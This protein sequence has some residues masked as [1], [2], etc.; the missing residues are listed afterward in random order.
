MRKENDNELLVRVKY[1]A[2]AIV[3]S[4]QL[5]GSRLDA[6]A[7]ALNLCR[8]FVEDYVPPIMPVVA[9]MPAPSGWYGHSWSKD[10]GEG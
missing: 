5:S 9:T 2:G 4:L 10:N 3:E 7:E 6:F 8:R 1:V